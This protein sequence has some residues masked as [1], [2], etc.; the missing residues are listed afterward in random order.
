M[1]ST[2][3]VSQGH[4]LRSAKLMRRRMY[5]QSA[6]LVSMYPEIAKRRMKKVDMWL[7]TICST[8]IDSD[9]LKRNQFHRL[10]RVEQSELQMIP[11]MH[12]YAYART[13]ATTYNES[14]FSPNICLHMRHAQQSFSDYTA[15][16]RR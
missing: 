11:T 16:D 6:Q 7:S 3:N 1:C 8:N 4:A 14:R 13:V 9:N 10:F 2:R 15:R 5:A 12:V